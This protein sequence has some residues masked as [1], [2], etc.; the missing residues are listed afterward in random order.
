MQN[1]NMMVMQTFSL[2]LHLIT[3]SNDALEHVE[4][5]IE[6]DHKHTHIQGS[7]WVCDYKQEMM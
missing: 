3:V 5:G 1:N 2:A 4:F 6:M 7:F